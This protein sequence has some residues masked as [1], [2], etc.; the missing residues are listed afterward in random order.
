LSPDLASY[1]LNFGAFLVSYHQDSL[2]LIIVFKKEKK[3]YWGHD[4]V[5]LLGMRCLAYLFFPKL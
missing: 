2:W 3:L 5:S 4:L 1:D